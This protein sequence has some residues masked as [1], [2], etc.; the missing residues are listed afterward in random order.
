MTP[1]YVYLHPDGSSLV[2]GRSA[3]ETAAEIA[4]F[5]SADAAAF[6]ALMTVVDAF[7]DMAIPIVRADPALRNLRAKWQAFKALARNRHLKPELMGLM[8]SPAYTSTMERF[9]HPVTQSALCCLLGLQVR[10]SVR[11]AAFI[12]RCWVSSTASDRDG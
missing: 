8:P 12:L 4:R 10:S 5:S 11:R 2:F 6:L 3:A 1:G 7:I 9:A